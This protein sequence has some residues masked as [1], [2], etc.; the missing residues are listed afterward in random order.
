VFGSARFQVCEELFGRKPGE[1][2]KAHIK[3][4]QGNTEALPWRKPPQ[5][6]T[7]LTFDE[8][9][10]S[11]GIAIGNKVKKY[12]AGNIRDI[13]VLVYLDTG[14]GLPKQSAI[15]INIPESFRQWRSVSFIHQT[16]AMVVYAG[17]DAPDFLVLI[18]KQFKFSKMQNVFL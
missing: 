9:L 15:F 8:V 6:Q 16:G 18:E 2:I 5:S 12:G 17:S 11:L 14:R 13:D 7:P 1:E 4:L 10:L 3:M